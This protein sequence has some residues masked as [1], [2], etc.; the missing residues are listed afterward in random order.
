MLLGVDARKALLAH[1][2]PGNVRELQHVIDRAVIFADGGVIRAEHLQIEAHVSGAIVLD[3]SEVPSEGASEAARE[4]AALVAALARSHG[5]I[6][7][8]ARELGLGR[9]TMWKL[10]RKHDIRAL[11][12]FWS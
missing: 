10:M 11:R 6:G 4:R 2:W 1:R 7:Q 9:T 12:R 8:A 3:V 5:R